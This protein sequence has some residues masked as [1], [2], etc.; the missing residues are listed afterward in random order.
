MKANLDLQDEEG[1]SP[2]M[3]AI[4]NGFIMGAQTLIFKG[5]DML[6]KNKAGED[7]YQIAMKKGNISMAKLIR[8][9]L[10]EKLKIQQKKAQVI[11]THQGQA[12]VILMMKNEKQHQK[13]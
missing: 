13:G 2:L 4:E 12:P 11:Q 7:A 9:Q 1:N 8:K 10:T 5:A 3:K 6:I